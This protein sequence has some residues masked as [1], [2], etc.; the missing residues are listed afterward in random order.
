MDNEENKTD[1]TNMASEPH[2][3]GGAEKEDIEWY[4]PEECE[5]KDEMEADGWEYTKDFTWK[6]GTWVCDHCGRLK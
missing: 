3:I 2:I 6:N 4:E 1:G 5:C